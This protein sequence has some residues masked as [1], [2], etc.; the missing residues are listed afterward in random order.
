MQ[1]R[2]RVRAAS[3]REEAPEQAPQ[4]QA[5]VTRRRRVT[6]P[7]KPAERGKPQVAAPAKKASAEATQSGRVDYDGIIAKYKEKATTPKNAIRSHC[8]EC[9]GGM[10]AEIARC[11][12]TGCSLYPF[13][14][15]KN[16]FHKL[17][18]DRQ[19]DSDE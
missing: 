7:A 6:A 11:T 3:P 13:R 4:E 9:M 5:T 12:S 14:M 16:P 18:K 1:A 15:G 17:S 19:E 8:V 10:I 2:R